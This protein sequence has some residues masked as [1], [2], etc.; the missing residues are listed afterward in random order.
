MSDL[1]ALLALQQLDTAAD[2]LRHRRATLSER[3]LLA[4]LDAELTRVRAELG[5]ATAERDRLGAEQA[6]LVV[7]D[8]H[9]QAVGLKRQPGDD[10]VD[11]VTE[12]RRPRLVPLQVQGLDDGVGVLYT[13]RELTRVVS[14]RP[15]ATAHRLGPDGEVALR[16]EAL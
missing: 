15:G 6:R 16:A 9:K 3:A 7:Q 4:G 1:T 2:Q 10:R 11:A 14:A 5:E 8:R 13:D 12:Q